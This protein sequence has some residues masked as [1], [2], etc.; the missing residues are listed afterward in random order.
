MRDTHGFEIKDTPLEKLEVIRDRLKNEIAQ[1]VAFKTWF[2]SLGGS[3][4]KKQVL[5]KYKTYSELSGDWRG[6][7]IKKA[8]KKDLEHE[9]NRIVSRTLERKVVLKEIE[10]EL[11]SRYRIKEQKVFRQKKA[12]RLLVKVERFVEK[13]PNS[14]GT[15]ELACIYHLIESGDIGC[16]EELRK[17][18]IK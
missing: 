5:E 3:Y 11:V 14:F 1:I 4:T 18:G 16:L 13:H 9:V 7:V 15:D 12:E 10:E 6:Y 17:Y 8:L 2:D